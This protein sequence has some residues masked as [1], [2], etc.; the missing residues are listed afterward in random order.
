M[1]IVVEAADPKQTDF[2]QA[3]T[4]FLTSN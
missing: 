2:I 4:P 3:H 1:F